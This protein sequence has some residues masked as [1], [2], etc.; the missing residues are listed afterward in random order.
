MKSK[1]KRNYKPKDRADAEKKLLKAAQE[2]FSEHGYEGATTRMIAEKAEINLGLITRYFG[3][4]KGLLIAAIE[5]M[6]I[7]WGAKKLPF[8]AQNNLIDES[9]KYA[10]YCFNTYAESASLFKIF[11]IQALTDPDFIKDQHPEQFY[12]T[13]EAIER[14]AKHLNKNLKDERH[15]VETYLSI[16][17]HIVAGIFLNTYLHQSNSRKKCF[18]LL[19]EAITH[20][21]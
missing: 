7:E 11:V 18:E 13:Q 15:Y 16:I 5:S 2:V 17:D 9:Q 4:K 12:Y 19:K 21:H 1:T 10:E 20:L 8:P 3:N 14:F 6:M